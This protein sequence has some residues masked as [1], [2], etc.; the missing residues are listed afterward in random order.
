MHGTGTLSKGWG[1]RGDSNRRG[2]RVVG[3]RVVG[4]RARVTASNNVFSPFCVLAAERGVREGRERS[5]PPSRFLPR[6]PTGS[7]T[8]HE[9]ELGYTPSA[10]NFVNTACCGG[11]ALCCLARGCLLLPPP[12]YTR[13]FIPRSPRG[14][15]DRFLR[16]NHGDRKVT[17]LFCFSPPLLRGVRL[18]RLPTILD[19]PGMNGGCRPWSTSSLDSTEFSRLPCYGP[20][21]ILPTLRRTIF[22]L[23]SFQLV[24]V[25]IDFY[26]VSLTLIVVEGKCFYEFNFWNGKLTYCRRTSRVVK[27]KNFN[28]MKLRYYF[29]EVHINI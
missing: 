15:V 21:I 27:N 25:H 1:E 5:K 3:L 12:F 23:F 26:T 11:V 2:L 19:P 8:L 20:P 9:A 4:S 13:H 14:S 6:T 10:I 18:T 22:L 16:S 29:T 7:A 28:L 17:E 24:T